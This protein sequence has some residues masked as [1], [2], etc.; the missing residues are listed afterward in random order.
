LSSVCTITC[1]FVSSPNK[2]NLLNEMIFY[3]WKF[4]QTLN[5]T[6]DQSTQR[7]L[8]LQQMLNRES[9][10]FTETKRSMV[11]NLK[12]MYKQV[13]GIF[14]WNIKWLNFLNKYFAIIL[15]GIMFI[16]NVILK[17]S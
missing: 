10:V 3:R 7:Y 8:E 14:I 4:G 11:F 13:L 16:K 12:N 9:F 17:V 15:S 6:L 1:C 5:E 2:S